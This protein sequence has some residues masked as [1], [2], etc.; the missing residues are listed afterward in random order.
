MRKDVIYNDKLYMAI[1]TNIYDELWRKTMVYD[2]IDYDIWREMSTYD[3]VTTW[4]GESL[5]KFGYGERSLLGDSWH[6][7]WKM[8]STH[9]KQ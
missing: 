1:R 5:E 4:Y 3:K 2:K 8:I 6:V 7:H 9:T